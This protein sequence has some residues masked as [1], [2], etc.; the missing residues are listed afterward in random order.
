MREVGSL[1]GDRSGR[2]RGGRLSRNGLLELIEESHTVRSFTKAGHYHQ[3]TSLLPRPPR[4]FSVTPPVRRLCTSPWSLRQN[5]GT[6]QLKFRN[7]FLECNDTVA[8]TYRE[9]SARCV[10][11]TKRFIPDEVHRGAHRSKKRS[12]S[13]RDTEQTESERGATISLPS[14]AAPEPATPARRSRA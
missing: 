6:T 4:G 11:M 2:G 1:R 14:H 10:V 5:L 3:F 8:S 13:E 12:A 7:H 9:V